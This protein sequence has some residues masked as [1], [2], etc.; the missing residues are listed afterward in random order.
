MFCH[1]CG[2]QI[3]PNVQFCPNCGQLLSPSQAPSSQAPPPQPPP[4][5]P[6][7]MSPPPMSPPPPYQQFQQ[8]GYIKARPMAWVGMGWRLVMADVGTYV[9]LTIV[10]M[11]LSAAAMGILQGALL[12]GMHIY[13]MKRMTGRRAEFGDIF[14][15][16][17]FFVAALVASIVIGVFTCL[18]SL[19]CIIPGLVIGAMYTFTYLFIM[20]K[21]LDFWPAM[22]ASHNVVRNDYF[23]FVMFLLLMALVNL[24]G[25]IC[26][27]VGVLV[28]IPVTLAAVT[29]AYQELVGFEPSTPDTV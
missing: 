20:D 11:V 8:P 2:T 22:Q 4:M 12:V 17:N 26:C 9:M 15:G 27:I 24:L 5:T 3:A 14:K 1:S 6:P 10:M 13:T 23:G 21:K 19:A 25:V 7:P 28:T 16:F 18:G 29:A